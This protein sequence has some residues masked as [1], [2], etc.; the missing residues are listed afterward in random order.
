MIFSKNA[1]KKRAF[2]RCLLSQRLC[3]FVEEPLLCLTQERYLVYRVH[4]LCQSVVF[5]PLNK[6]DAEVDPVLYLREVRRTLMLSE[7]D[8]FVSLIT[9]CVQLVI[10]IV[11]KLSSYVCNTNT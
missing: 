8:C 10:A 7:L 6:L 3:S 11:I 2:A 4:R 1:S 5:R 9:L